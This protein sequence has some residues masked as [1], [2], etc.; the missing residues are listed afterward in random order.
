MPPRNYRKHRAW[1]NTSCSRID[2]VIVIGI[3]VEPI[4]RRIILYQVLGDGNLLLQRW[5]FVISMHKPYLNR[6]QLKFL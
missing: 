5:I 2:Q 1:W 4:G 6:A 3:A